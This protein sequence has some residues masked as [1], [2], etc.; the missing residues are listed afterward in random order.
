MKELC[1]KMGGV[2]LRIPKYFK[3]IDRDKRIAQDFI[4]CRQ[5]GNTCMM[6]YKVVGEKHNLK[7]RRIEQI[8]AEQITA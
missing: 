1:E 8:V 5:S 3:V 6:S 2:M 4:Q 7:P